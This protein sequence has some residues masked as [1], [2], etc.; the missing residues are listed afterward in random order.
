MIRSKRYLDLDSFIMILPVL[1]AI[2]GIGMTAFAPLFS[3][4][5]CLA[6]V[7]ITGIAC[8][9]MEWSRAREKGFGIAAIL[10]VSEDRRIGHSVAKRVF[11]TSEPFPAHLAICQDHCCH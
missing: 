1:L 11:E 9:V 2:V 6:M 5:Y 7:V 8:T 3:H 4:W 10:R